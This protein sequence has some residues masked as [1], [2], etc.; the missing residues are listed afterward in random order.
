MEQLRHMK[1]R[2]IDCVASQI[3]GNLDRTDTKELGEAIDMI[4]DLSEAI[5]Y[6]T[7]TEAMEDKSEKKS[8]NEYPHY[9]GGN[10]SSQGDRSSWNETRNYTPVMFSSGYGDMPM[11]HNQHDAMYEPTYLEHDGRSYMVKRR[12][13]DGRKYNSD[14]Q[15]QMQ[16]LERY[17]QELTNELTDMIKDATPEEKALLQQKISTLAGKIK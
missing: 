10:M 5:Y 11:H 13:M 7:I 4:K 16:E 9:Y 3:N 15:T 12:Y 17:A 14:K 8:G 1:S 2:L 6:C